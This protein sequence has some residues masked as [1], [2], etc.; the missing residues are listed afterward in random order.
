MVAQKAGKAKPTIESSSQKLIFQDGGQIGGELV[1][2]T[3]DEIVWR[4]PD[5]SEPLRFPRGDVRRIAT[6]P[7]MQESTNGFPGGFMIFNPPQENSKTPPKPASATL[8]LPGGDWLFGDVASADGQ[9][10]D[11][12]LEDGAKVTVGRPQI[13]WVQFGIT[14]APALGFS[15]SALDMEGWLPA[16]G[17]MELAGHTLI[18]RDTTWIGHVISPPKHFEVDF[19]VPAD[20]EEGTRL[21]LQP[22]GPQPNCYGTGTTEIRFGK[23]EISAMLFIDKFERQNSPLPKEVQAEKEPA[24]YRVYY[25]GIEKRIIVKRNGR[26]LGDWKFV[27]EK[28]QPN[29]AGH[30]REIQINGICFDREDRGPGRE[31]LKFNQ[32]R[33]Q[34]WNGVVPKEEESGESQDQ[35]TQNAGA[36]L[37]GKLESIAAKEF[38]FSGA[39]HA[40]DAGTFL[41][42][43]NTPATLAAAEA[44]VEFGLQGEF[45]ARNLEIRDGKLRCETAFAKSLEVPMK[46]LQRITFQ[47]AEAPVAA[48]ENV[49]VFKNGDDLPGKAL[50]AALNGT[51]RWR[52]T[53]GQEL[54]FQTGR[55]AGI[56]LAGS[57]DTPPTG[58]AT[59]ELRTG[60]RLRGK[61][62]AFDEKQLHLEHA[63]LGALALDRAQVWHLFPNP[64]LEVFE[65]GRE[66]GTWFWDGPA[67]ERRGNKAATGDKK[68]R[69]AQSWVYL[70]GT[71]ILRS[72]GN[73]TSFDTDELPGLKREINPAMD[74]FEVRIDANSPVVNTSNFIVTLTNKENTTT[75]TATISYSDINLVVMNAASRRRP[76]WRDIPLQDKLGELNSRRALRLFVNTKTGTCDIAVNGVLFAHLGQDAGDRLLK[77]QYSVRIQPYPIAGGPYAGGASCILSNI[78]IGPWSGELPHAATTD[79]ATTA[80]VNGDA[81]AGLPKAMHDGKLTIESDLGELDLPFEK[82]LA[83]D[84]GGPLEPRH[85]AARIRLA[86]GTAINVDQFNWNG[87]QLVAHSPVL[88]DLRLPA[89]A[90]SELIF[91]PAPAR[92]PLPVDTKKVAQKIQNNGIVPV[93]P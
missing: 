87:M 78:W 42:F 29:G 32:L 86:D 10:F 5:A 11:L 26:Q 68:F 92:A 3:K 54:E 22:F 23:K 1:E 52:T 73:T 28:D 50:S 70:D 30:P 91:D 6:E 47:A 34:P 88:G 44:K 57:R 12:M 15:G 13:E 56:R 75:L 71:Y 16:T 8:K 21:W 37:F 39:P 48:S 82:A 69:R 45:T 64:Q 4:R 35:L 84:F 40:R 18:A 55:I 49:L 90:A 24:K 89:N 80:L 67:V 43:A 38:I 51:V 36:P 66:P 31:V 60:E 62:V 85:A 76:N 7:A 9:S 19:E 27:K 2:I 61:L 33:I 81:A 74:R 41:R 58:G 17:T 77:S 93:V 20:A 25:D 59:V 83:I 63:Q 79:A 46:A 72:N 53:H 14:P 65:G